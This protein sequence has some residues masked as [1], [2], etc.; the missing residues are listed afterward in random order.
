LIDPGRLKYLGEEVVECV[1]CGKKSF[2]IKYY[3]YEVP[4]FGN[5]VLEIG[6]CERCGFRRNDVSIVDVGSPVRI[7]VKI[8]GKKGLDALV[9]KASTAT[10]KIPELG[11]EITPGPIAPGYI[12]TI[13]GVLMN[14]LDVIPSECFNE[15]NPCNNK[16]KEL[17]KAL[18]GELAFTLIIEDPLGKSD[19]KGEEIE[20]IKEKITQP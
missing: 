15:E 2:N 14:I 11:I 20:V 1:A 3:L 8:K 16:V 7:I 13:E 17:E 6:R 10:I 12:T 19:V 18:K 5:I 9:V 4:Y